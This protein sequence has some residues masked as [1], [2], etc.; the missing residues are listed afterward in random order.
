MNDGLDVLPNSQ[1]CLLKNVRQIVKRIE[2]YSDPGTERYFFANKIIGDTNSNDP[3]QTTQPNEGRCFTLTSKAKGTDD[4]Q[5][6]RNL[7]VG[8]CSLES[9]IIG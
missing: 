4:P 3:W 2:V 9:C 7:H 5:N 1:H 6:F 8:I